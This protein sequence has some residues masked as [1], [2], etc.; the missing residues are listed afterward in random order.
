VYMPV[1]PS[2]IR[3]ATEVNSA[4]V[5]AL[6]NEVTLQVL[7]LTIFYYRT[8]KFR[9]PAS[10]TI[11]LD[12]HENRSLQIV[13]I[14]TLSSPLHNTHQWSLVKYSSDNLLFLHITQ[15]NARK[16]KLHIHTH[17]HTQTQTHTQ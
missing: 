16:F 7:K 9:L 17:T 2:H 3:Q 4:V 10:C 11:P 14:F 6:Q 8:I 15:M 12:D 1:A 5:E 13:M